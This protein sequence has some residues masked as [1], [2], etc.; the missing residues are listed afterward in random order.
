M[1]LINRALKTRLA[2]LKVIPKTLLAM[3][4]LP[5]MMT[6]IIKSLPIPNLRKLGTK[7][8]E[9]LQKT[10][11]LITFL[12]MRTAMKKLKTSKLNPRSNIQL[13]KAPKFLVPMNFMTRLTIYLYCKVAD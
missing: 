12:Q 7:L 8:K 1:D 2:D 11:N 4:V 5:L 3:K 13:N 10:L 6:V 9:P